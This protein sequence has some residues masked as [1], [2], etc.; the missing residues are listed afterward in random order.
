MTGAGTRTDLIVRGLEQVAA[1]LEA[2][3]YSVQIPGMGV[4]HKRPGERF[5]PLDK[6]RGLLKR[7]T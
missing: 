5:L 6:V 1:E 4:W 2:E 3:P 7:S